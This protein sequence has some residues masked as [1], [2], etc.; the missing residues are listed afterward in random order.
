MLVVEDASGEAVLEQKLQLVE[1]QV[2]TMQPY[3][4]IDLAMLSALLR[5]ISKIVHWSFI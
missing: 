1:R 3:A 2:A 5:S 4:H